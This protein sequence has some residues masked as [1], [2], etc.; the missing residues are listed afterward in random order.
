ML[1]VRYKSSDELID[2]IINRTVEAFCSIKMD[3]KLLDRM[4]E[5]AGDMAD[6]IREI[7]NEAAALGLCILLC[8]IHIGELVFFPA[9]KAVRLVKF[10]ADVIKREEMYRDDLRGR[11][12]PYEETK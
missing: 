7:A 10:R 8:F 12:V 5:N 11:F 6:S 1:K 9:V 3:G 2:S 4:N